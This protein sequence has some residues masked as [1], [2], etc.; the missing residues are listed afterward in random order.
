[1]PA[2]RRVHLAAIEQRQSGR[3]RAQERVERPLPVGPH[4]QFD[5]GAVL[6]PVFLHVQESLLFG[7]SGRRVEVDLHGEPPESQQRIRV[8]DQAVVHPVELHG[9]IA[10]ATDDA[11]IAHDLDRVAADLLEVVDQ[12]LDRCAQGRHLVA[13][14]RHRHPERRDTGEHREGRLR[15]GHGTPRARMSTPMLRM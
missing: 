5:Q 7:S 1:M 4:A 10:G 2:I 6:R 3:R 11:R 14:P 13:L 12:P 15:P 8:H 9:G